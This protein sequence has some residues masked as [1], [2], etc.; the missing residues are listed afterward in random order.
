L[1][2]SVI[3]YI[4]KAKDAIAIYDEVENGMDNQ[5][6]QYSELVASAMLNKGLA[7]AK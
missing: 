7:V 3:G 5:K 4:G 2:R 1:T 6:N